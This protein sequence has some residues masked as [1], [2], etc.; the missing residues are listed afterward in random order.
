MKPV[1][2]DNLEIESRLRSRKGGD[3]TMLRRRVVDAIESQSVLLP[4]QPSTAGRR[5]S[6]ARFSAMIVTLV[7]V[8]N[9]VIYVTADARSYPSIEFSHGET[10]EAASPAAVASI[11]PDD[12]QR[13]KIYSRVATEIACIPQIQSVGAGYSRAFLQPDE[14]ATP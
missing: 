8:A 14:E 9:L 6:W 3:L 5:Q 1:D 7:L 10:T 4:G 2:V 13:L 12:L 11:T